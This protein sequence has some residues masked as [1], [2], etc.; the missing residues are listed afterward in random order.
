MKI[1]QYS[2]NVVPYIF[3]LIKISIMSLDPESLEGIPLEERLESWR[4][5]LLM[6][7]DNLFAAVSC[8]YAQ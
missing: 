7:L 3:R 2:T 6:S 4:S 5:C 1:Y 8:P